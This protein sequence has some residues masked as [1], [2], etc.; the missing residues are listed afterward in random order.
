MIIQ[1]LNIKI[2]V[3][4]R[5]KTRKKNPHITTLTKPIIFISIFKIKLT[6]SHHDLHKPF[7]FLF[8]TLLFN[9]KCGKKDGPHFTVYIYSSEKTKSMD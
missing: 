5:V 9:F 3:K 8:F 1:L 6:H 2:H 7:F 4:I